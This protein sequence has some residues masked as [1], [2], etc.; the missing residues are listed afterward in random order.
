M[1]ALATTNGVVQPFQVNVGGKY[2]NRLPERFVD[3]MRETPVPW[4]PVGY[5]TYK[6]TY[7]RHIVPT[8]RKSPKEEYWETLKRCINGI[9]H[10][11]GAFTL[12]E[13]ELLCEYLINLRCNFSGR[14]LWQLG[15][16]TVDRI[17]GDSL[18]ACWQVKVNEP[19][20][21]FAFA[22][23]ELMLGGGVGFSILPEHV[24]EI[25]VVQYDVEVTRTESFDCDFIVTDNREG[26]VK[27]LS[28]ILNAFFYTG[29]PVSYNPD[30]LRD[31]GQPIISFGGEASGS[32]E[33]VIGISDIVRILKSRV[34]LKLRPIDC[35]D[36]MNIIG[37]IV[38]SGN[39]RRSA[40]IA[41]GS[42]HD[43]EFLLAKFWGDGTI[44]IPPW[45]QHSNNTV[46]TNSIQDVLP[47]F[48]YGYE[49]HPVTGNAQGEPYGLFNPDLAANYG[50]LLDGR[51]E[52]YNRYVI[53][54]NPCGEIMLESD[55]ACN[56]GE[57]Y[58]PNLRDG[59]EFHTAAEL[60]FKCL[61]TISCL[62]F[63][64]SRTN[65]VVNRNRRIGLGVTGVYAAPHLNKPHLYDSVYKHLGV[66]DREYSTLLGNVPLS[67]ARTTVKP[68]GTAAKLPVGCTP[69][70]NPAFSLYS[71]LR[72]QFAADSPML[73]DLREAGYP[74]E[75]KVNIDGS[76]DLNVMVVSFPVRYPDGTPDESIPAIAQ[77]ENVVMLQTYWSDNAVSSTVQYRP[78]ELP[79][80]KD[81]LAKNYSSKLKSISF[82][83]HSG[84]GF[85]QAPNEP[86]T[87][88]E[89]TRFAASVRPISR[90]RD[91]GDMDDTSM[92]GIECPGGSCGIK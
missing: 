6:R 47:E 18:Q 2:P 49:E 14:S 30:C 92:D 62:K 34:G 5:V 91:G 86:L 41:V 65:E 60:M 37:R 15:T 56:L 55:E 87:L 74:M 58:L 79:A 57:L 45:R 76:R 27:L 10:I 11:G 51:K 46:A 32:T 28:T 38:V 9:L 36:I 89:Y 83:R 21:P 23:E 22:F 90:F 4:G 20:H 39:V 25:P 64:H 48:W 82:C 52:G 35:L 43:R 88:E 66:V 77:L 40:E 71:K 7:S 8:D 13:L 16:A 29:K 19:I 3:Q 78:E 61:K 85:I 54:P 80:I 24:Y 12:R 84:H 17:G 72:I 75:P 81:W 68:S 67:I 42:G 59:S 73:P 69:G 44:I 33:L 53:G 31:K 1:T 63:L 50:R 26:F 70:A